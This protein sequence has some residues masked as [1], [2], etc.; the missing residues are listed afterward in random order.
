VRDWNGD[1]VLDTWVRNGNRNYVIYLTWDGHPHM[2]KARDIGNAPG[3]V[4]GFADR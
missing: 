2:D 3:R 1:G 4:V